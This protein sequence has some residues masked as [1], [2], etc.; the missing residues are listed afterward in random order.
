[1]GSSNK[2]F[3]G[4]M[5]KMGIGRRMS[6]NGVRFGSF[7]LAN[8]LVIG[9]TLFQHL[10][11]HKTTWVSPCGKYKNQIYHIAV[12]RRHKS[13]LLDVQV[14]QGNKRPH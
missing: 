8:Y 3:E 2:E 12:S 13:S 1:M 7:C 9:G 5:G 10:D 4:C 6:E 14:K 11:I